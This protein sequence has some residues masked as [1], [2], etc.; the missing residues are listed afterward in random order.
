MG[1]ELFF[2]RNR[3][4]SKFSRNKKQTNNPELKSQ[5]YTKV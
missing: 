4:L 2:Y 5:N 1:N 3:N